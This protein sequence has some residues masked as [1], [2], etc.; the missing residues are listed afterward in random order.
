[1][2]LF[3]FLIIIVIILVIIGVLWGT[4]LYL[5][6]L[7]N[8]A[9]DKYNMESVF[10][11]APQAFGTAKAPEDT[12]YTYKKIKASELP[13]SITK[14]IYSLG[15]WFYVEEW[16]KQGDQHILTKGNGNNYQPSIH[17]SGTNNNLIINVQKDSTHD[18]DVSL[19]E[20]IEIPD[21]PIKRW[22]HF[23]M[24]VEHSSVN[25]Y[26]NSHLVKSNILQAPIKNNTG[27]IHI[28]ND[29]TQFNGLISKILYSN[30]SKD[31]KGI[32]KIYNKGPYG[33][34]ITDLLKDLYTKHKPDF[35][36]MFDVCNR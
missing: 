26:I 32:E 29:A 11:H 22:V 10:F 25:I 16:N 15:F 13:S 19:H 34:S 30:Y 27:D 36:K 20:T 28:N 9:G 1:M 6:I 8:K 31:N 23:Y 12:T 21:I 2:S 24:N 35:S 4:G 14:D 3:T 17:I 33:Y 18:T 7:S 5:M